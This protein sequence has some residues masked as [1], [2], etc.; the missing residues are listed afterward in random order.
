MG[1]DNA[2][3]FIGTEE[4]CV[5]LHLVAYH[6]VLCP[7]VTHPDAPTRMKHRE[8]PTQETVAEH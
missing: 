1:E 2:V 3:L 7:S 8:H 6:T 4:G 5:A